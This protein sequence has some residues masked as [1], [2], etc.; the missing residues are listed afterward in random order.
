MSYLGFRCSNKDYTY[1]ILNG[2]KEQPEVLCND[3]V[4]FPKDF[5]RPHELKWFL[6]EIEELLK[7]NEVNSIS[8]KSTEVPARKGNSYDERVENEAMILLTAENFGITQV[9]KKVKSTI[10]KDLGLKGKGKYLST[11]LDVSVFP[12]FDRETEKLKDA[13]LVAWSSM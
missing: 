6:Q 8:I 7:K 13:I 12:N 3:T 11:K 10:A 5:S 2:T 4:A 9:S 1:V